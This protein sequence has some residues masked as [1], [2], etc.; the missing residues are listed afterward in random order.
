M[1]SFWMSSSKFFFP[2]YD[3]SSSK[4]HYPAWAD[5]G[6]NFL[7]RVPVCVT[8]LADADADADAVSCIQLQ[9]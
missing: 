8:D 7:Y 2:L 9:K 1:C 4:Y 5:A 6:I 3:G